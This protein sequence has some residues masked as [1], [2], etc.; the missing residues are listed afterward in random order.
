[1]NEHDSENIAGM[2][3]ELGFSATDSF[4]KADKYVQHPRKC[5]Q[6]V[7]RNVGTAQ[8]SKVKRR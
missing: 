8:K 2:L 7:F 4:A 6:A 1:M 3:E 5:G